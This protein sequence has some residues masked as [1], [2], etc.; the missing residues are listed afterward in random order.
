MKLSDLGKKIFENEHVVLVVDEK[1]DKLSV[2][3]IQKMNGK[4]YAPL[5]FILGFNAMDYE[6]KL[7]NKT[8]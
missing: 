6:Y 5:G 1:P 4:T 8:T 3:V 2:Y 7:T